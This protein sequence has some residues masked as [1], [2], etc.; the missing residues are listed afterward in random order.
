MDPIQSGQCFGSDLDC[1]SS[2][3]SQVN[4]GTPASFIIYHVLGLFGLAGRLTNGNTA[5]EEEYGDDAIDNW[6]E[7][8]LGRYS[9]LVRF[10][11]ELALAWFI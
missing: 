5:L 2:H 7:G 3:L 1:E 9:F 11:I 6:T 4:S 8:K 10:G